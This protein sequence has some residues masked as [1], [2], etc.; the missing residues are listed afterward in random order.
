MASLL[1]ARISCRVQG[2]WW[3]ICWMWS[4]QFERFEEAASNA[5]QRLGQVKSLL[6]CLPRTKECKYQVRLSDPWYSCEPRYTTFAAFYFIRSCIVYIK[7]RLKYF[8]GW[9]WRL[10]TAGF[11]CRLDTFLILVLDVAVAFIGFGM[12]QWCFDDSESGQRTFVRFE[13]TRSIFCWN[14]AQFWVVSKVL[15]P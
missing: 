6:V 3:L 1:I 15:K 7:K 8:V 9:K 11:G 10:R 2:G 4:H 13:N 5:S 12:R 14:A